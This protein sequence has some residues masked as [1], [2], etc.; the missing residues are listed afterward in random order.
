MLVRLRNWYRLETF[1]FASE[2][3]ELNKNLKTYA[4]LEIYPESPWDR[5]T[6]EESWKHR[7]LSVEHEDD[8]ENDLNPAS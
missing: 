5:A 6:T 7:F 1:L 4:D 8:G 3:I 2:F